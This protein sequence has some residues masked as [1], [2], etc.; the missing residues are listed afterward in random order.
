VAARQKATQYMKPFEPSNLFLSRKKKK[1]KC[2]AKHMEE[3]KKGF[4]MV[5]TLQSGEA[6][7]M[8][9]MHGA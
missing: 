7:E 1:K 9:H 3:K 5:A 2:Q 4:S 8:H 6:A